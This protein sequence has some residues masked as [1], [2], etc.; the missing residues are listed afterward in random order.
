MIYNSFFG[1]SRSLGEKNQS[2]NDNV[3]D[4]CQFRHQNVIK[5]NRIKLSITD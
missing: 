1:D 2:L 4:K 5:I 3:W